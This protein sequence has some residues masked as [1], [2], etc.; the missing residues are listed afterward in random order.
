LSTDR[1][2]DP[3]RLNAL[4]QFQIIGTESEKDFDNIVALAAEYTD[5]PIAYI[6]FVD[7]KRSWFKAKLG[8]DVNEVEI[9]HSFCGQYTGES[10][11]LVI[12]NIDNNTAFENFP[13][14]AQYPNLKFYAGVPIV[15]VDGYMLG[16]LSVMDTKSREISE[17]QLK[18]MGLLRDQIMGL[19]RLN[20]KAINIEKLRQESARKSVH[21][22][23]IFNFSIDGVMIFDSNFKVVEWNPVLEKSF[24]IEA[25]YAKGNSLLNLIFNEEQAKEFE[26]NVQ[27]FMAGGYKNQGNVVFE[28]SGIDQAG[29]IKYLEIGVS[30]FNG[31]NG[32]YFPCFISD[33]T[34]YIIA[35][36]EIVSQKRF[37]ETVINNIPTDI[38]VFDPNHRYVFINPEGIKNQEL[39]EFAIGKDDIEYALHMNRS[40][41][42][43][44]HRRQHFKNAIDTKTQVGWEETAI[45][46]DGQSYTKLRRFFPIL[47][48]LNNVNLVIGYGLD[49]SDRKRLEEQQRSLL[50]KLS[51]QNL[52]LSDFCNIISHNL[53]APLVSMTM[54]TEFIHSAEEQEEQKLLV[55]KLDP[56]LKS[57]NETFDELVNSLQVQQDTKIPLENIDIHETIQ[58]VL[59]GMDFDILHNNAEFEFD[60][61]SAPIISFPVKYM[62]SIIQNLLSNSIKYRSP[63]RTP[64]IQIKTKRIG[65]NEIELSVTDNGL[66]IDIIRYKDQIF[67]IGKIFHRHPNAK[68]YGLF[69]TKTQVEAMGGK[70]GI[71]STIDIG[72]TFT[73]TFIDQHI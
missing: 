7:G 60:L 66:G 72:T 24:Q 28:Q 67:K 50:E 25:K 29:N 45:G 39:R 40:I 53:R 43:A 51:Y 36:K 56:V 73:I 68:G 55:S 32:I 13:L 52:Q 2:C 3:K 59:N 15:T 57:L 44:L 54:L 10:P 35:Q 64:H 9:E 11:Y 41:E 17:V 4:N 63:E 23:N 8:I 16:F 46:L 22:R 1:T 30:C 31:Q 20:L 48:E 47:D 38:V 34:E 27:S 5:C 33:K 71:E 12:N 49:I 61:E 19:L 62:N 65:S 21:L 37:Y 69:M 26:C 58:R 70:I 14:L 18:F 42:P 6:S